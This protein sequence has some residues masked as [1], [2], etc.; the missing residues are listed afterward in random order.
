MSEDFF[1]WYIGY[2]D[3]STLQTIQRDSGRFNEW[4]LSQG[5]GFN[6]EESYGYIDIPRRDKS[7]LEAIAQR[8]IIAEA[9]QPEDV[10]RSLFWNDALG[11]A[12]VITLLSLARARYYSAFARERK[13]KNEYGISWGV[14]PRDI[15]GTWDIVSIGNLGNFISE[16]RFLG[17]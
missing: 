7:M 8:T 3:L 5:S 14:I 9:R 1:R 2:I 11:L 4:D 10:K 12:D 16:S 15:E 17:R 6:L 13:M